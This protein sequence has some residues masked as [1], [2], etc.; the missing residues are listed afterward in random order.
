VSRQGKGLF[1]QHR[2][3]G[4]WSVDFQKR[5]DKGEQPSAQ[6]ADVKCGFF[7]WPRLP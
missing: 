4:G 6:A 7:F 1:A 5:N 3:R 2:E